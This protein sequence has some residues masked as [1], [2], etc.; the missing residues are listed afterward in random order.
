MSAPPEGEKA[1]LSH[2]RH[3]VWL[4]GCVFGGSL[5]A[6]RAGHPGPGFIP[7]S[8]EEAGYQTSTSKRRTRCCC[9]SKTGFPRVGVEE[10]QGGLHGGGFHA[11]ALQTVIC[12]TFY[13][14]PFQSSSIYDIFTQMRNFGLS[15]FLRENGEESSLDISGVLP[16][17]T[18]LAI[19]QAPA[20]H[21]PQGSCEV[22]GFGG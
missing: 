18:A 21:L 16:S 3:R 10:K 22:V 5:T 19:I 7:R 8:G 9:R 20:L 4:G 12:S 15:N 1:R 2:Q 13:R 6:V 11:A 17:Q 14:V